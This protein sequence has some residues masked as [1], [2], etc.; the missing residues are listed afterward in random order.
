MLS[1]TPQCIISFYKNIYLDFPGEICTN[2]IIFHPMKRRIRGLFRFTC[3]TT[4]HLS[5]FPHRATSSIRPES[6]SGTTV[7]VTIVLIS[8]VFN[9]TNLKRYDC[10]SHNCFHIFC[11]QPYQPS[12]FKVGEYKLK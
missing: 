1:S 9:H 6:P 4:K 8:S 5:P 12:K 3:F 7:Q 10:T 11:V 2:F